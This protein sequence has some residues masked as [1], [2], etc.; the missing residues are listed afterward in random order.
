MAGFYLQLSG[1]V[2]WCPGRVES[3][4]LCT[5]NIRDYKNLKECWIQS[6]G[7]RRAKQYTDETGPFNCGCIARDK[8]SLPNDFYEKIKNLT[9]EKL[10]YFVNI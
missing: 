1:Q 6:P 8:R 2:N 7:C 3:D 9:L 4:T 10:N 5:R